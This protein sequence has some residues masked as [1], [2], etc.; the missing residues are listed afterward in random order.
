MKKILGFTMVLAAL[1]ISS[2]GNGKG[3]A[4]N[5]DTSSTKKDSTKVDSTKKDRVKK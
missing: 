3:S 1:A 4:S 5:A 2:C